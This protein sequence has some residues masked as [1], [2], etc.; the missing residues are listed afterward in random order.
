M[1]R[2]REGNPEAADELLNRHHR[3]IRSYF[4]LRVDVEHELLVQ[5]TFDRLLRGGASGDEP[6]I[7]DVL[8]FSAA[9]IVLQTYL[10]ELSDNAATRSTT[11]SAAGVSGPLRAYKTVADGDETVLLA[12]CLRTI[13]ITEQDLVEFYH[14]RNFQLDHIAML[15]ET[16]TERVREAIDAGVESLRRVLSEVSAESLARERV[17]DLLDQLAHK[18]I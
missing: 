1:T 8:L 3:D 10:D 15:L 9:R 11:L 14:M 17:L 18:L 16:D 12:S 4:L 13:S 6:P 5:R 2:W 7:F